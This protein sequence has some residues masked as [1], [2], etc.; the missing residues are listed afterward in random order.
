VTREAFDVD[1]LAQ[2]VQ[3][4]LGERLDLIVPA[5][6]AFDTVVFKLVLWADQ[7]GQLLE[8]ARAVA[9]ARPGRP[10]AAQL[11]ADMEV[12]T[13][14]GVPQLEGLRPSGA[15]DVLKDL[16]ALA[17][18]YERIRRVLPSSDERTAAMEDMVAKMRAL[19]TAHLPLPDWFHLSPS[20]GDRLA[21]VVALQRRPDQRYLRWLSE[22]LT[23]EAPFMG[24]HA[25][26]A[27]HEAA[28]S[29]ADDAL[30]DVETA[31]R[32]AIEWT[33]QLSETTDRRTMLQRTMSVVIGRTTRP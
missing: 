8:L 6:T 28:Q 3:F 9:E 18:A 32:D 30:D 29:L 22:R 12:A 20:A 1:S 4:R 14:S 13:S 11:L 23:T 24:Y 17:R 27:L 2:L 7:R 5:E 10:D 16:G 33:K 21:A 25:A 31:V 26:L 19:P 15:N